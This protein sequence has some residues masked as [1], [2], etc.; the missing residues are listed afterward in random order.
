MAD[1]IGVISRGEIVLVEDKAELD[2]QA[3]QETIDAA[4]EKTL[5]VYRRAFLYN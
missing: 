5:D 1:R 2:A 4:L 3:R